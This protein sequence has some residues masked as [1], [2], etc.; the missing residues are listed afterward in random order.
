MAGGNDGVGPASGLEHLSV[1]PDDLRRIPLRM[2]RGQHVVDGDDERTTSRRRKQVDGV[3]Q[4]NI[5]D[6]SLGARTTQQ[7]P[8]TLHEPEGRSDP[9]EFGVRG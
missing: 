9:P 4:V 1:G 2:L 3:D 5:P 8:G 7:P 6:E